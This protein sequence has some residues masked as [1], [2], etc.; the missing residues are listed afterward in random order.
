MSLQEWLAIAGTILEAAGAIAIV[1]GTLVALVM[2]LAR[3]GTAGDVYNSF[4][5]NLARSILL[6]LE[7]LVG[8]DIIRTITATPS[9]TEV[10]VLGLIVLIRTLLSFTLQVEVEGRWPWEGRSRQS[11]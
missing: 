2:A 8:G 9:I 1:G 3:G 10:V 4:R 7:L 5:G 6:G 11:P